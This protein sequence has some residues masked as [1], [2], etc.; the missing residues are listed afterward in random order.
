MLLFSMTVP[1]D[2][3]ARR[4]NAIAYSVYYYERYMNRNM[5]NRLLAIEGVAP[6][7]DSI[8]SRRYPLAAEVQVVLRRD[9]P[10]DGPAARLRDW[11]LNEEGQRL[12]ASSG[13]VPILGAAPGR[14]DRRLTSS[15]R[16]RRHRER[17]S[18]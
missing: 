15:E 6:D 8:R 4:P 5:S 9:A 14:L 17:R 18:V 13:Y 7:A 3:V 1:I 10:A 16:L 11:L 12:V 2:E